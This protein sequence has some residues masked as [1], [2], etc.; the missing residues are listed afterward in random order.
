MYVQDRGEERTV[1]VQTIEP[2][3][4]PPNDVYKEIAMSK[5]KNGRATGYYQ[6]P[7]EMKKKE[8]RELKKIIYENILKIWEDQI[9]PQWWKCGI[10]CPIHRRKT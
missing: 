6:N 4:E 1:C 9:V 8:E 7:A 5:L 10:I 2:Y 3:A